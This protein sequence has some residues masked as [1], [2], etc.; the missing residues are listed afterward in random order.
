MSCNAP[1]DVA[2][3]LIFDREG[4]LCKTVVL[5]DSRARFIREFNACPLN[6]K[7]GYRAEMPESSAPTGDFDGSG[8][9][10][11]AIKQRRV[12]AGMTK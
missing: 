5:P 12:H 8:K 10:A 11:L 2:T 9:V 4:R 6:Q 3:V 1:H 7:D